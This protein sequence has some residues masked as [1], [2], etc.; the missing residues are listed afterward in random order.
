MKTIVQAIV[1]AVIFLTGCEGMK[2]ITVT[3]VSGE[4]SDPVQDAH[5]YFLDHKG[6]PADS[7]TTDSLGKVIF[8]SG[9][10]S[11][12][13]GGPKFRYRIEKDGFI[14]L[15]GAEKWP[16]PVLELNKK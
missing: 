13:F 9:F 14:P 2:V 3:V 11:M 15:V 7:A 5:V 8:N 16:G 10:T 1:I 6:L 12:M 4:S